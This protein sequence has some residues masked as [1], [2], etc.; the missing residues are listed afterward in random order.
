MSVIPC[1]VCQCTLCACTPWTPIV[2]WPLAPAP[3]PSPV[4]VS[5]V[6]TTLEW[7]LSDADIEKI[8]KRVVEL[9]KESK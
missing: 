7:K 8:A 4:N 1:P 6:F 5:S 2:E 3:A 9:L